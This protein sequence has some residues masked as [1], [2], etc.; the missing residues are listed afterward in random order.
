LDIEMKKSTRSDTYLS[1]LLA[2]MLAP[3]CAVG[4]E[5]IAETS[6]EATPACAASF[7]PVPWRFRA[8]GLALGGGMERVAHPVKVA[9]PCEAAMRDPDTE[10]RSTTPE[11]LARLAEGDPSWRAANGT[12]YEA[13]LVLPDGT[14]FGRKGV[15][16]GARANPGEGN[17]F[18]AWMGDLPSD[19]AIQ[20]GIDELESAQHEPAAD[21]PPPPFSDRFRVPGVLGDTLEDDRRIRITSVATLTSF[22]YRAIGALNQTSSAGF[23][24]CTGT[25]VGPRHV[26]TAAHCVLAEDGSWTTSGWFHPGQTN[27]THPNTGGTAVSWSG[28]YARDWRNSRRYDYALLYLADRADSY[29]LGWLGVVWWNS[30]GSYNGK[31]ATLYGYPAKTGTTDVRKCKASVLANNDCDGW[32][33]GDVDV[34]DSNAYRS[35]EQLEYDIDTGPAQSG[36]SVRDGNNVMGVHWG[37][38]AFGG[39]GPSSAPRNH[40]A[41]FR[42]SMWDD[43]CSWIGEVDSAFGSHSLC[44]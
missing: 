19:E 2:A 41:R 20:A 34:L 17:A 8:D 1:A 31:T 12:R 14:A 38:A 5:D 24:G 26:I 44:P 9:S 18:G 21:D 27:S 39:C 10:G 3:A 7:D 13:M 36:S 29:S 37:C 35:D 11:A 16:P 6:P 40:A 23:T 15:A 22:P 33:Y 30:A 32:M 42:Q 4:G 43:I 28:V 25:K